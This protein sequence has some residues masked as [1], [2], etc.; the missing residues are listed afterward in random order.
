MSKKE[1]MENHVMLGLRKLEGI[2]VKEFFDKYNENIQDVFNIK[3]L[4]KEGLLKTNK[5][6][7][8][9]PEDKIYI[10]N[11]ILNKILN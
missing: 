2:D 11:Y 3:P 8:Y 1:D 5:T 4:L 10:M 6:N 9:I 7:I